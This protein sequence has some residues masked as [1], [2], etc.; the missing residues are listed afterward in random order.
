MHDAFGDVHSFL[1]SED[2]PPSR[3]KLLEILN[4]LPKKRKLQI[5]L[6][7]TVDAGEPFVKSTYRFEGDGP[8]IFTAYDEICILRATIATKH[9]PNTTAVAQKLKSD[10]IID[11][12]KTELPKYLATVNDISVDINKID[13]WRRHAVELPVGISL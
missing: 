12:L 7:I 6:A 8:L 2:L 10:L 5:E 11:G 1:Q 4:D 9:F 13:W 3:F